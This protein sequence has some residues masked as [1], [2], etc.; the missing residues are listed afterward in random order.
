MGLEGEGVAS[1]TDDAS[2][3]EERPDSIAGLSSQE[4]SSLNEGGEGAKETCW[5]HYL[6]IEKDV[7]RQLKSKGRFGTLRK[8]GSRPNN[9]DAYFDAED[10][11]TTTEVDLLASEIMDRVL[12]EAASGGLLKV[13]RPG[14]S[15]DPIG[16]IWKPWLFHR[17]TDFKK[18]LRNQEES[19]TIR[20]GSG[21]EDELG[22]HTLDPEARSQHSL[23]DKRER[24]SFTERK[25]PFPFSDSNFNRQER[26]FIVM[27]WERIDWSDPSERDR[28][29]AVLAEWLGIP[30]GEVVPRLLEAHR[31]EKKRRKELNDEFSAEI[32]RLEESGSNAFQAYF[33][34]EEKQSR[35][36]SEEILCPL[37]K[38]ALASLFAESPKNNTLDRYMSDYN[39]LIQE[40]DFLI[41]L[42]CQD[43][44]QDSLS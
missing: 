32:L 14:T 36:G 2:E 5:E 4:I 30:G 37:S 21:R 16:V 38:E 23:E 9:P 31:R 8:S 12:K 34:L 3:D 28:T 18:R 13:L 19:K 22:N 44:D 17:M 15:S 6:V 10:G 40:E 24:V 43:P 29:V 27:Y 35:L 20:I 33:N 26:V 25:I 41:Q 11:E 42:F 1:S 7:I 39:K